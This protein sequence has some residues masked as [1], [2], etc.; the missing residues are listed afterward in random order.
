MSQAL[1]YQKGVQDKAGKKATQCSRQ[2]EPAPASAGALPTGRQRSTLEL[3]TR[4]LTEQD[5][6][7]GQCASSTVMASCSEVTEGAELPRGPGPHLG[8]HASPLLRQF[9]HSPAGLKGAQAAA[10][11][12]CVPGGHSQSAAQ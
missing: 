6:E 4:T 12:A 9:L 5:E 7:V 2:P 3:Q 11:V 10:G 1:I 8:L